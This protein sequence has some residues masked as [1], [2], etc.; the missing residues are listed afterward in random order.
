MG[1]KLVSKEDIKHS[2]T[3]LLGNEEDAKGLPNIRQEVLSHY[4]LCLDCPSSDDSVNIYKHK[5]KNVWRRTVL[6][7]RWSK[8]YCLKRYY[9]CYKCCRS[10]IEF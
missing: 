1:N 8:L 10:E 4:L 6:L 2:H 9:I 3:S 5:F 7:G